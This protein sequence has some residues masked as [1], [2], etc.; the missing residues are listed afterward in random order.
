MISGIHAI[1]YSR[2]AE[3]ARAF[4]RHVLGFPS[5]DAGRGWLIFGLPPAELG[6][7]PIEEDNHHELYLMCN[8]VYAAVAEL[9]SKGVE[10]TRPVTDQGWGLLTRLRIPGGGEM[11]LYQ[12]KHPTA[13]P[14]PLQPRE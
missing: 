5:V 14:G 7:H 12:P 2:D 9:K 8:D 1:V 6:V 3:R 13:I 10:F 4:F 11:G